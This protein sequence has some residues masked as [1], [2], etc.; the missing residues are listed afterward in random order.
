ML[1]KTIS[2]VWIICNC[3]PL[4]VTAEIHCD[5]TYVKNSQRFHMYNNVELSSAV[6]KKMGWRIFFGKA[7]TGRTVQRT[8][9]IQKKAEK[10]GLLKPCHVLSFKGT[11]VKA[12][13]Y[14]AM[15]IYDKE[16]PEIFAI[17]DIWGHRWRRITVLVHWNCKCLQPCQVAF[18]FQALIIN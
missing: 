8:A 3:M 17:I 18:L 6:F 13:T 12:I 11:E 16:K 1:F 2:W 10:V 14:S 7:S 15:Q 5:S 9:F 4:W